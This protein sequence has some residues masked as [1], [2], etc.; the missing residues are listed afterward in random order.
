MPQLVVQGPEPAQLLQCSIPE[1]GLLHIGRGSDN[2]CAVKWDRKVSRRHARMQWDGGEATITCMD[3]ALNPI[4]VRGT[5]C[6]QATVQ[7]G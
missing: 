6:Q 3:G 4:L 1:T 2:D 7:V 5:S